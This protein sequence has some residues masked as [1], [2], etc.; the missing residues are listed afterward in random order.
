MEQ[1]RRLIRRIWTALKP[2]SEAA[3]AAS[4]LTYIRA[5]YEGL[6]GRVGP[7]IQVVSSRKSVFKWRDLSTIWDSRSDYRYY[8][9]DLRRLDGST[10]QRRVRARVGRY[11]AREVAEA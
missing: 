2:P 8:D 11:G 1:V 10:F 5:A 3:V 9:L 6:Q 4:D 7:Y